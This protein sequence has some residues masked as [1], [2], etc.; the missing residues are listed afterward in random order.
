ME[1]GNISNNSIY[2]TYTGTYQYQEKQ[3]NSHDEEAVKN[4]KNEQ[5][6][7]T[8]SEEAKKAM[9]EARTQMLERSDVKN[10]TGIST[11]GYSL[12]FEKALSVMGKQDHMV[13][14]S[15]GYDPDGV[16]KI[17]EHFNTE[18]GTPTDTFS[19]HVNKMVATYN[20][21]SENLAEKYADP[22]YETEYYLAEDG[23]VQEL[24]QEKEQEMLDHA[25]QNHSTLMA[26]YTENLNT[27]SNVKPEI[28]YSSG[29]SQ[30]FENVNE[31]KE[32]HTP[33]VSA[34]KGEI[35]N[36][37]YQAFMSAIG[38]GNISSLLGTEGSWNHVKLD[39]GIS[40]SQVNDLNKI[41]DYYANQR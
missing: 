3:Y 24:T 8:I 12:A 33:L 15:A 39:L 38:G 40:G 7:L 18:K 9:Q 27:L 17:K 37:A 2:G 25:Y 41:W 22:D 21:M 30:T 14:C 10:I 32:D 6:S 35:K 13:E 20:M 19:S 29:K 26:S 34:Q 28:I 16:A 11:M 4:Q 31:N 5:D 1:Y 23:S 36:I